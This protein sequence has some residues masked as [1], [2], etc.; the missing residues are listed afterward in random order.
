MGALV[1]Q[2]PNFFG[3]IEDLAPLAAAA[4]AAGA[5]LVVCQN[6]M[7]LGVLDAPGAL[8]ADIAVGD[9]QVLRRTT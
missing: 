1:V 3:V 9:V 5:L 8:G 6:P 4:H 7:T 2:Q